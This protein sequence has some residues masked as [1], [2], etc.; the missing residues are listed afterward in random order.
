MQHYEWLPSNPSPLGML[1]HAAEQ[2]SHYFFS[3]EEI[4]ALHSLLNKPYQ[5][6]IEQCAKHECADILDVIREEQP[7][8]SLSI[9]TKTAFRQPVA[10]FFTSALIRAHSLAPMLASDIKTCLQEAVM[11]SIIYGNLAIRHDENATTDHFQRYLENI[12]AAIQNKKH[13]LKRISIL[14]WFTEQH[15]TICVADQG[16]GFNLNQPTP[17]LEIPYGRG[18]PLIRAMSHAVW[19]PKPNHLTMQFLLHG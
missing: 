4:G 11:N 14:A 19:Q 1:P 10:D 2:P 5:H 18:L 16:A 6:F 15:I 9:T 3:G 7:H 8:L 17:A 13:S 12:T